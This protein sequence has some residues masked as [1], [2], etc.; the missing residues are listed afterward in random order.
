MQRFDERIRQVKWLQPLRL[1]LS[2]ALTTDTFL[3]TSLDGSP[4]PTDLGPKDRYAESLGVQ[5]LD[6]NGDG[7]VT[8]ELTISARHLNYQGVV[9]GG[10]LFT[11]VEALLTK[12]SSRLGAPS[13]TLDVSVT[14]L[15]PASTG[16]RLN[17]STETLVVRRRMIVYTV[18]IENQH[19]DLIAVYQATVLRVT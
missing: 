9:H 19:H 15:A 7:C 2:S 16:D 8:A 11:M 3:G 5:F 6:A 18:K 13:S 17:A 10:V 12:S 14:V 4:P 1:R